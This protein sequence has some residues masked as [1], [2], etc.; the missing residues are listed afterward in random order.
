MTFIAGIAETL[1]TDT[2]ALDRVLPYRAI[3]YRPGQGLT[4]H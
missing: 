1:D 2:I 3:L 4:D